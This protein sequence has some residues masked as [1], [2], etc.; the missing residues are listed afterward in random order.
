VARNSSGPPTPRVTTWLVRLSRP[1]GARGQDAAGIVD[2]APAGVVD[3]VAARLVA[4]FRQ[5]AVGTEVVFAYHTPRRNRM[6]CAYL[7]RAHRSG[8]NINKSA[9]KDG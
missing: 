5:R 4:L 7:T 1:S 9:Y 2:A 6:F 3:A 8:T